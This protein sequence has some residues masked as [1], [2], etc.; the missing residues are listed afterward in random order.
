MRQ[1][2]PLLNEKMKEFLIMFQ[3]NS[4]R[5]QDT[6]EKAKTSRATY[7]RWLEENEE[8]KQKVKE[9]NE[10]LKDFVENKIIKHVKSKDAKIS[11]D[12]CKFYA[13]TKMKDR[14]YVERTELN[15]NISGSMEIGSAE[16]LRKVW[17][18]VHGAESNSDTSSKK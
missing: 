4:G 13:K 7:Y 10:S 18:E 17:E 2:E 1:K 6:C 5:I 9:T 14:G 3:K 15:Q 12:M 16:H 11:A 8:F